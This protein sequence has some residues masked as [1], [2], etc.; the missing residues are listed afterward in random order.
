[1]QVKQHP[2]LYVVYQGD[3]ATQT[4]GQLAATPYASA[5]QGKPFNF[6]WC[7]WCMWCGRENK[8]LK[9]QGDLVKVS[10]LVRSLG[11]AEITGLF[12]RMT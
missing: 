7:V 12:V 3:I 5:A 4:A 10:N 9:R 1:M 11:R 6:P 8:V 2:S